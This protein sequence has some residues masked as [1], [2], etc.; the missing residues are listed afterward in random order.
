MVLAGE[1]GVFLISQMFAEWFNLIWTG[2]EI[3]GPVLVNVQYF[4]KEAQRPGGTA[5]ACN[6]KQH[7][8][9]ITLMDFSLS[10]R[11]TNNNLTPD[12]CHHSY[13]FFFLI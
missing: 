5:V 7:I 6:N 4:F 8:I 9:I 3:Q 10:E 2:G 11:E 13:S 12:S 1:T